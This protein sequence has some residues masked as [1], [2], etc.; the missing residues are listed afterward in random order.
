M[1][2]LWAQIASLGAGRII[3]TNAERVERHYFDTHVLTP[4]C[5]RPL[6]IEGLQQA[7]DTRRPD[8]SI[9]K[10]FKVLIEDELD[11]L[12]PSGLRLVAHPA[13]G[14][15]ASTVVR[16]GD[17]V[18][19]ACSDSDAAIRVF[20]QRYPQARDMEITGAGLED[21]FLRLVAEPDGE[22]AERSR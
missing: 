20:L 13:A 18:T 2:R 12:F 22:P 8:V 4:E 10:Q 11:A 3:L 14:T 21:A 6:L 7:R 17:S 9:H 16:H 5:Y 15:P 1:R 19:L